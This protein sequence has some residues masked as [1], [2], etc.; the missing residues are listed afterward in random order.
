MIPTVLKPLRTQVP[1]DQFE[2]W[3]NKELLPLLAQMRQ[4]LNYYSVQSAPYSTAATGTMTTIWTSA[5]IAVGSSVL[6]DTTIIGIADG[7]TS[8]FKITGL[9][10]NSGTFAQEGATYAPFTQ[11]TASFAVQY[12][13]VDNHFEVQAQDDGA[14]D[15]EW[16]AIV[17][18]LEVR[19][20]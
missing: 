1:K 14:L 12:L 18:A 8:A 3:V 20:T 5:D 6:V 13:V 17:S 7:A 11:N 2:P 4:A 19:Q 10:R 15:V 9:F 16:T